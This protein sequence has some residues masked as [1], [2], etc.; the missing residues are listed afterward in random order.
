MP[1]QTNGSVAAPVRSKDSLG[2]VSN[3]LLKDFE[4]D[5]G[6]FKFY[7]K[8]TRNGPLS[9]VAT[10]ASDRGMLV[11]VSLKTGHH[12]RVISG[13][14]QASQH[15][16]RD[17]VY[18]RDFSDDYQADMYGAFDFVL[19]ELSTESIAKALDE[20]QGAK[21]RG[22]A[23]PLVREDPVLGHFAQI[24]A[25]TLEGPGKA[26]PLFVEQLGT[27]IAT[28]VVDQYAG[29]SGAPTR[30]K[31]RLSR[32]QEARAKEMLLAEADGNISIE[33][34]AA[35]CNLSRSYF[36][37]AFRETTHCTPHQWLIQQR[38]ARARGLLVSSDASLAEIA[39]ACGFSDQS[40]FSRMFS[41][42]VGVPPGTWRR[43]Q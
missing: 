39:V 5:A 2:C 25:L 27:A 36:I 1:S 7:R 38:I 22:F 41:Q 9:S 31:R 12:R 37:S 21:P 32:A 4:L 15:F 10:P 16:G 19:M 35:A 29:P 24:L 28:Y 11:G 6:E 43:S 30:S 3:R 17:S 8:C 13:R 40:H 42:I 23:T 18:L 14:H 20:R 34:I 33:E 26:S